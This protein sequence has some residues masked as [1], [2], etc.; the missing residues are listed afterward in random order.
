MSIVATDN[1]GLPVEGGATGDGLRP[2][3]GLR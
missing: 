2:K 1:F 3:M